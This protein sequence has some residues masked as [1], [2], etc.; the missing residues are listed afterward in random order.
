MQSSTCTPTIKKIRSYP[1]ET[2]YA[3]VIELQR[4]KPMHEVREKFGVS[5]QALSGWKKNADKIIATMKTAEGREGAK[6]RTHLSGAGRPKKGYSNSKKGVA[7]VRKSTRAKVPCKRFIRESEVPQSSVTM[8]EAQKPPFSSYSDSSNSIPSPASIR[9]LYTNGFHVYPNF[10]RIPDGLVQ[11]LK[12]HSH[13]SVLF[14]DGCPKRL[15]H[16]FS[17]ELI[18]E[19][20]ICGQVETFVQMINP[21]VEADTWADLWSLP[22]NKKQPAHFD[23]DP[24]KVVG[25]INNLM[26]L[27]AVV[28]LEDHSSLDVWVGYKGL[29][30]RSITS[31]IAPT[32]INL[33]KG[34]VLIFLGDCIHAGSAYN[35]NNVRLH[36]YF[37]ASM[38]GVPRPDNKTNIVYR[39]RGE[40]SFLKS[41]VEE[42]LSPDIKALRIAKGDVD[43]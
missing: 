41:V 42:N 16:V 21:H 13:H 6:H 2:K 39:L 33:N 12:K 40:Y 27:L 7:V 18:A 35:N 3:A 30:D 8:E 9:A 28:A 32:T 36:C 11:L 26:P 34:D 38:S 24:K 19:L 29:L 37:P 23:F 20:D 4:L 5:K 25:L 43:F 15:M 1:L 31:P 14:N 10:A 17:P 22:G